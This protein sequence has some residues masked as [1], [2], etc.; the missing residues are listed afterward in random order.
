MTLVIAA[1]AAALAAWLLVPSHEQRLARAM[2]TGTRAPRAPRW[3][4]GRPGGPEPAHRAALG[5][6]AG[7]LCGL[8]VDGWAGAIVAVAVAAVL[9]VGLG[10]LG[11][12]KEEGRPGPEL[13]DALDLLASCLDSGLPLS[14]A[15]EVVAEVSP[16]ATGARLAVVSSALAAGRAGHEAW[17]LIVDDAAWGGVA[18]EVAAAERRGTA[19][20]GLLRA[21][22]AD[23]RQDVSDEVVK[24]ARTVGVRSV[25]PLM[26]CFLPAFV[27]VGV[28][29][30][31][32]GLIRDLLG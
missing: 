22:A 20:S 14:R 16:R 30:I 25:L 27:L 7:L 28:V 12:E 6:T 4:R 17:A 9:T 29:P 8:V 32:A 23:A 1:C 21:H 24:R 5:A 11:G 18:A 10:A 19:L 31:V 13:P 2:A 26:V 15:V 3:L